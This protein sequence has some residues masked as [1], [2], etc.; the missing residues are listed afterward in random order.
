[1]FELVNEL[2]TFLITL[3][4]SVS[5]Y[6]ICLYIYRR[7][8]DIASKL[9]EKIL[10][11]F[12]LVI[13]A[14]S[15]ILL[16]QRI[17]FFFWIINFWSGSKTTRVIVYALGS[18]VVVALLLMLLIFIGEAFE[19]KYRGVIPSADVPKNY[20]DA[21]TSSYILLRGNLSKYLLSIIAIALIRT[22]LVVLLVESIRL[23]TGHRP[24]G[25]IWFVTTYIWLEAGI[26]SGKWSDCQSGFKHLFNRS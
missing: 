4:L 26:M 24:Q 21:L 3:M 23:L 16:L 22:I 13:F 15:A 1:M 20:H 25:A 17:E 10:F 19:R 9:Y 8:N 12:F 18:L 11:W 14:M 2:S 6:Y 7:K 5:L